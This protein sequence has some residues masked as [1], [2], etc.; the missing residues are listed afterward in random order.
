[1][2]R[3]PKKKVLRGGKAKASATVPT[4]KTAEPPDEVGHPT[5]PATRG[6]GRRRGQPSTELR[7]VQPPRTVKAVYQ[8]VVGPPVGTPLAAHPPLSAPPALAAPPPLSAPPPLAATPPLSAPPPLAAPPPV[9]APFSPDPVNLPTTDSHVELEPTPGPAS[10]EVSSISFTSYEQANRIAQ[11][12]ETSSSRPETPA[13]AVKHESDS[14]ETPL[15]HPG[16]QQSLWPREPP[17]PRLVMPLQ[18]PET[19]WRSC[20]ECNVIV[21]PYRFVEHMA[22]EHDAMLCQTINPAGS[23]SPSSTNTRDSDETEEMHDNVDDNGYARIVSRMDDDPNQIGLSCGCTVRR[24]VGI[25]L[26]VDTDNEDANEYGGQEWGFHG[27]S[28]YGV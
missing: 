27:G 3:A 21:P 14:P 9:S 8:P 25:R 20:Y 18:P 26:C 4:T 7:R 12:A 15:P 10:R 17:I 28:L 16:P 19:E 13:P 22:Y 1:M 6:R 2:P 11:A 5:A 24:P 23:K